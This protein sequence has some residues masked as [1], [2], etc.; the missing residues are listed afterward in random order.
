MERPGIATPT[1]DKV[2]T[3]VSPKI[4]AKRGAILV[5]NAMLNVYNP[6]GRQPNKQRFQAR[7][8]GGFFWATVETRLVYNM[9]HKY[10]SSNMILLC[11]EADKRLIM[12]FCIGLSVAVNNLP[13]SPIVHEFC[14]KQEDTFCNRVVYTCL[15]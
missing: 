11:A 10:P 4:R 7:N 15:L 14:S 2:S 13:K 6:A 1:L 12:H 9:K 3:L 5:E 8:S